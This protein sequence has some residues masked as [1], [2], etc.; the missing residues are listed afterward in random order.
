VTVTIVYGQPKPPDSGI[1]PYR[2]LVRHTPPAAEPIT[3]AEAKV[4]C[5]VDI[6]DEDG[7]INSLIT[8]AREYLEE[9][10]DLSIL[11]QTWEAR[12]DTFP[13]W[14]VI[15]PR[16]PM[17]AGAVTV[18]YRDESG[19]V[20]TI[21]SA[22]DFQ[23]DRNVIPGRIYPLYNGVW[24]AVRGDE[25]SVTVRWQAGYGATGANCPA[26]LRQACLLLVS[27]WFEMRQPVVTGYSQVLPVPHTFE[28]L[29]AVSGWGG[30][31]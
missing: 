4:Q 9:T 12:Y 27:H 20:R 8:V 25:N 13:L 23:V 26:V 15:L 29:L 1:T 31:R 19:T 16:P 14:E 3:L 6:D 28:T 2:S 21:T 11:T 22:A 10:L 7:Y 24:P 17:A 30:Y 18:E 5:R